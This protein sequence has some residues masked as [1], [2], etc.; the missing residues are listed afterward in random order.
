MTIEIKHRY[1]GKV[2]YSSDAVSVKAAVAEAIKSGSNLRGSNLSG[3]NLRGSDLSYS[4]LSGS[5][6]SYSDL[7]GSNL[8]GSDLS[9]SNLRYSDLRGS[10]L[11]DTIC[12]AVTGLPSGMAILTP[13]P[14]GWHLRIGCWEGTTTTLRELIAQDD[15]WPD[16]QDDQITERR[17][18]LAALADMC[19]SWAATRTE[20]LQRIQ[21]KW[22]TKTEVES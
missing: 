1:S 22:A 17:P 7:S 15:G 12:L 6:L 13:Q 14:T 16:A 3:S 9:G 21:E 11:R 5:D 18:M 2:L 8:S 19:D 10:D 4:N 20:V